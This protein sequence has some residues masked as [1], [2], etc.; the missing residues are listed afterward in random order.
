MGKNKTK[1]LSK[2]KKIIRSV[3]S[4]GLSFKSIILYKYPTTD[5]KKN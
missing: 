1:K 2:G 5:I 3:P 4:V